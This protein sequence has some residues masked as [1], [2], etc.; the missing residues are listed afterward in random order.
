MMLT[1]RWS[2]RCEAQML[3][4]GSTRLWLLTSVIVSLVASS[5]HASKASGGIMAT[6]T[7]VW[8]I[9]QC[10]LRSLVHDNVC[11]LSAYHLIIKGARGRS[12]AR[13]ALTRN[14]SI[15]PEIPGVV[16]KETHIIRSRRVRLLSLATILCLKNFAGH[17]M[18]LLIG[19]PV[20]CTSCFR[21][22]AETSTV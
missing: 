5:T 15:K 18:R 1:V 21:A 2:C 4:A 3:D 11:Q 10:F 22:S 20:S 19:C 9:T 13:R 12:Q 17:T 16:Q 7:A 6:P 8:S 14:E